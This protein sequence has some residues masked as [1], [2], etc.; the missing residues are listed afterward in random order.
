M[1]R[2]YSYGFIVCSSIEWIIR[3]SEF[4]SILSRNCWCVGVG[5]FSILRNLRRSDHIVHL[6]HPSWLCLSVHSDLWIEQWDL[7]LRAW[8]ISIN[9]LSCIVLESALLEVDEMAEVTGRR[10]SLI[11]HPL[12]TREGQWQ[13]I[14]ERN[15]WFNLKQLINDEQGWPHG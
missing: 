5:V 3:L 1:F 14:S 10:F 13:P 6:R 9:R 2:R 7:I 4:F 15:Q 12:P 8:R 11:A